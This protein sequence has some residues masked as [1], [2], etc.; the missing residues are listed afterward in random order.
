MCCY[1]SVYGIEHLEFLKSRQMITSEICC[2]LNQ[3]D[4]KLR[5]KWPSH[6]LQKGTSIRTTPG[7]TPRWRLVG[8]SRSSIGPL[9][10]ARRAIRTRRHPT[11]TSS[12]TCN[13]TWTARY[14]ET[15]MRRFK[16]S[17]NTSNRG[18]LNSSRRPSKCYLRDG[19]R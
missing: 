11:A 6:V 2:K 5:K 14:S 4:E 1:W 19:G 16:L 18:Q 10:N 17:P 3:L 15:R 8:R 7:R 9:S 12:R 13:I